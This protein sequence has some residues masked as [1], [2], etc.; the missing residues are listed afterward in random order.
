MDIDI[1]VA[2][3]EDVERVMEI[4]REVADQNRYCLDEPEPV[5]IFQGFGDSALE[6]LFAPWFAKTDYVKLRNSLLRITSY[7]VCYTKLLRIQSQ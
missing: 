5:I 3:K 6:I 2:Y 4:L 1:G 7:N